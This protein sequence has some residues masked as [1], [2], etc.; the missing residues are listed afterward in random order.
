MNGFAWN[1]YHRSVSRAKKQFIEFGN[2]A[3]KFTIR[4]RSSIWYVYPS[5]SSTYHI[6]SLLQRMSAFS[7]V[8]VSVE[9]WWQDQYR[10]AD[11][12]LCI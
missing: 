5:A 11:L 10:G 1:F 8:G 4:I 6:L 2:D 12:H 7:L 3:D 9:F